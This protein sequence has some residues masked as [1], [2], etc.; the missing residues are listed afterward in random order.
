MKTFGDQ[1]M[2]STFVDLNKNH[3]PQE[4]IFRKN[5]DCFVY[6]DLWFDEDTPSSLKLECQLRL[7]HVRLQ[8]NCCMFPLRPWFVQ[9]RNTKLT[10]INMLL[11]V[12]SYLKNNISENDYLLLEELRVR[13]FYK[14]KGRPQ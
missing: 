4:F 3:A 6:Y 10:R 1:D 5:Q 9:G 8:C 11:N 13:K 2:I 7:T 12:P 14:P